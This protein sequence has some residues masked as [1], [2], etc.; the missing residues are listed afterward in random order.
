MAASIDA[1]GNNVITT[2][3]DEQAASTEDSKVPVGIVVLVVIII[4]SGF[5]CA[6]F[7]WERHSRIQTEQEHVVN[8]R[9][10]PATTP[11]VSTSDIA[12]APGAARSAPPPPD[13]GTREQRGVL[14]INETYASTL[15]HPPQGVGNPSYDSAP[16]AGAKTSGTGSGPYY[17]EPA[18]VGADYEY[19]AAVADGNAAGAAHPHYVEP[20]KVGADYEYGAAVADGN[21][22]G[23]AHPHYVE[24]AKVG[25]DVSRQ[26]QQR[27][28]TISETSLDADAFEYEIPN[29]EQ[30][31][32]GSA[33]Q[34][35]YAEPDYAE[36]DY[37]EP[38]ASDRREAQQQK[39]KTKIIQ[40]YGNTDE[41]S[42]EGNEPTP[43]AAAPAAVADGNVGNT[44]QLQPDYLE[45]AIVGADYEYGPAA[46]VA[47]Y[48]DADHAGSRR[49]AVSEE[50]RST[51]IGTGSASGAFDSN[52][53]GGIDR[54]RAEKRLR[55][56]GNYRYLTRDS[57]RKPRG[58]Q[59]RVIV[60]SFIG[61][62]DCGHSQVTADG[63]GAFYKDGELLVP[64]KAAAAAEV[65]GSAVAS[66]RMA[67]ADAIDLVVSQLAKRLGKPLYAIR[68][69]VKAEAE[70]VGG[71]SRVG[72]GYVN[73]T[74]EV[75][76]AG[77]A[78][79]PSMPRVEAERK[80]ANAGRD[81]V[82]LLRVNHGDSDYDCRC[83]YRATVSCITRNRF[84]HYKM[85]LVEDPLKK[86]ACWICKGVVLP[87]VSMIEAAT[88]LLRDKQ[89]PNPIFLYDSN[90][91]RD[92]VL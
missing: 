57:N 79:L 29:G 38:A 11:M 34:P 25:A 87:E 14:T 85:A 84:A 30:L 24:P 45:P 55:A 42:D 13:S 75:M 71:G 39:Q 44:L 22:A 91:V 73:T 41:L 19:G 36:P 78:E 74:W 28:A 33:S 37:V 8:G 82:F 53:H 52:H 16:A 23:A 89:V 4:L 68:D 65:P 46:S 51:S 40:I 80:L 5:V 64:T 56:S 6:L 58:G 88:G 27:A 90:N 60:V 26:E 81:G 50:A 31:S 18:K 35:D 61:A 63:N 32:A 21:A 47:A 67:L 48:S 2:S 7:V 70:M 17:L 86:G 54:S 3:D 20:A 76:A 10:T 9:D 72:T 59:E 49:L 12:A 77:L 43:D 1:D 69:P 66:G 62:R 15:A 83:D 92:E